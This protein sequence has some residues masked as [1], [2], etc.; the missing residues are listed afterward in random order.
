[1]SIVH[2]AEKDLKML[3]RWVELAREVQEEKHG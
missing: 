2:G 3:G 1:M